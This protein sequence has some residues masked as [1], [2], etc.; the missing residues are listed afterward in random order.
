M[1]PTIS[2]EHYDEGTI[3]IRLASRGGGH[4]PLATGTVMRALSQSDW[5]A[6]VGRQKIE[7]S[8]LNFTTQLASLVRFHTSTTAVV[9]LKPDQPDQSFRYWLVIRG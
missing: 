5:L 2:N 6:E 4:P 1:T 8:T 3:P 7:W 9:R